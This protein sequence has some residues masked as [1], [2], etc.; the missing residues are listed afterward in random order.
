[1]ADLGFAEAFAKYGATLRNVQWS[2]SAVAPDGSLV[3]SLWEH[4]FDPP[5]NGEILCRGS[6][7]RWTGP[8][9]AEFREKVTNAFATQ[10]PVRVVI[11]HTKQ[12]AEVEAGADASTLHKTFSVRDDWIGRVLLVE[13]DNYMFRFTRG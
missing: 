7:A 11:S 12:A 5:C 2:V 3:V 9:N 6:F 4:H 10:Q 1:V 8:G 13:G